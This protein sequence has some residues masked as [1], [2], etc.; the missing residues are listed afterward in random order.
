MTTPSPRS[1]RRGRRAGGGQSPPRLPGT[2]FRVAAGRRRNPLP[3]RRI[4]GLDF[5]HRFDQRHGL[6][7]LPQDVN[8]QPGAGGLEVEDRL[9]AV[10][11][12]QDLPALKTVP[13]GDAPFNDGRLG[14]ACPLGGQVK[15]HAKGDRF[16]RLCYRS[17]ASVTLSG[18]RRPV[19]QAGKPDVL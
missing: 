6:A 3:H 18:S 8:D 13:F 1:A 2:R 15:R 5:Q 17:V 10:D 19:R 11:L 7:F 4:A 12:G 14:L 16:H 9:G